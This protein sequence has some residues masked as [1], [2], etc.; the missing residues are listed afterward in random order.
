MKNELE[1]L[2]SLD[3]HLKQVKNRF[4]KLGL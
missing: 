1:R 3:F 2:Y 4:R